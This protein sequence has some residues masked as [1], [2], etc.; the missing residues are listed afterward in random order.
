MRSQLNSGSSFF[1]K[2]NYLA[3]DC[4]AGMKLEFGEN[5]DRTSRSN[6]HATAN[7]LFILSSADSNRRR[8]AATS[9]SRGFATSMVA[10]IRLESP[11]LNCHRVRSPGSA[12]KPLWCG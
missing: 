8:S 6:R 4:N 12:E 7:V 5:G 1:G 3:S 9:S 11:D 10:R 2:R